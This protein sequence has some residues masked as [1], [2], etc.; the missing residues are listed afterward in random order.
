MTYSCRNFLQ[1]FD[2]HFDV[3]SSEVL[4]RRYHSNLLASDRFYCDYRPPERGKSP[5]WP[6][7][8]VRC[9]TRQHSYQFL[10]PGLVECG[11]RRVPSRASLYLSEVIL[12]HHSGQIPKTAALY[13]TSANTRRSEITPRE[14]EVITERP[15]VVNELPRPRLI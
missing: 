4:S 5:A 15:P 1:C 9:G 6:W 11:G 12:P 3:F 8:A 14:S 10:V 2:I 13:Y 7:S